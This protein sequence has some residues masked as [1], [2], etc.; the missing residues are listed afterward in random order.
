MGKTL[1]SMFDRVSDEAAE[2]MGWV[3]RMFPYFTFG[4]TDV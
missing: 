4:Q 3:R 1:T 2:G